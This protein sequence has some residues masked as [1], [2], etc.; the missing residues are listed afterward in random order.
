MAKVHKNK[1]RSQI[2]KIQRKSGLTRSSPTTPRIPALAAIFVTPFYKPIIDIT[3]SALTEIDRIVEELNGVLGLA[4]K[5]VD[6]I[7]NVA[8][9]NYHGSD[10]LIYSFNGSA[11]TVSGGNDEPE[12]EVSIPSSVF[13][14]DKY[15][16]VV[17][18]AA[19][20]F[21]GSK[22]TKAEIAST[23]ETV[24]EKAFYASTLTSVKFYGSCLY[25]SERFL[26]WACCV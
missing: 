21:S 13:Y 23:V 19:N 11:F 20:A 12:G 5:D 8:G 3:N 4:T 1:R 2:G 10:G 22:I 25:R 24:G 7:E 14:Q 17:A 6:A 9:L 15:Y 26:R 16:P 18:I